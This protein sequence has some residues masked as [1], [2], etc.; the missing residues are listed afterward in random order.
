MTQKDVK[1]WFDRNVEKKTKMRGWNSYIAPG[2]CDEFE[3]DVEIGTHCGQLVHK[4]THR[5]LYT[6]VFVV[7]GKMPTNSNFYEELHFQDPNELTQVSTFCEK[8]VGL[9]NKITSEGQQ[10]SLF[11]N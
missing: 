9:Y 4:L 5:H 6:D 8:T 3:M 2:I 7:E 10:L 1:D 11:S